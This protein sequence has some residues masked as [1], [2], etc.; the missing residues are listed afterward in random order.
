MLSPSTSKSCSSSSKIPSGVRSSVPCSNCMPSLNVPSCSWTNLITFS[1]VVSRMFFVESQDLIVP[2][3]VVKVL[4]AAKVPVT[5][6]TTKCAFKFASG[7]FAVLYLNPEL[8]ILIS[9]T[10]PISLVSARSLEEVPPIVV[11]PTVGNVE[12][13][14]PELLI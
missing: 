11:T 7:G 9:L 6:L 2:V 12:Y 8:L 3:C 13:P 5:S 4:F 1:K 14:L 10:A